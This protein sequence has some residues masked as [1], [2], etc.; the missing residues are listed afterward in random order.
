[1]LTEMRRAFNSLVRRSAGG[2]DTPSPLSSVTQRMQAFFGARLPLLVYLALISFL[3]LMALVAQ[4]NQRLYPPTRLSPAAAAAA[5]AASTKSTAQSD[6]AH[7]TPLHNGNSSSIRHVLRTAN[8]TFIIDP[9]HLHNSSMGINS[10]SLWGGAMPV[11]LISK[12][13]P[14]SGD[15]KQKK[16]TLENGGIDSQSGSSSD[17]GSSSTAIGLRGSSSNSSRS[18]GGTRSSMGYSVLFTLF[19][20]M[21]ILQVVRCLR[22]SVVMS[23]ARR[24]GATMFSASSRFSRAGAG[25]G[26]GV[27]RQQAMQ[28][29]S[30]LMRLSEAQTAGAGGG[31]SN[32]LRMAL[33]QRDFTGDDYE[34]LQELD[35]DETRAHHGASQSQIDQLPVHA[36]TQ[37]ELDLAAQQ[38]E[39]SAAVA[40]AASASPTAAA[41]AADRGGANSLLSHGTGGTMCNICLASYEV[42]DEVR[43]VQ[44]M[45]KFHRDCIDP[46][47]RTNNSCPICKYR[48]V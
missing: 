27:G 40:A 3:F 13:D 26:A 12:F 28:L 11:D 39:A 47:L 16:K 37:A 24:G 32:R 18:S 41:A 34:M 17:S 35:D 44:C 22:Q 48:A 29:M 21:M 38:S 45:H 14:L 2:D 31:L 9:L 42:G 5:A 4:S 15:Q 43:T 33:L 23:T 7:N 19:S 30:Q 6:P 20:W 25:A 8:G 10:S 1:M 36:V 46:W